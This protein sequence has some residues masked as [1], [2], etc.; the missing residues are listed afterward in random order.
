MS[1]IENL[2]DQQI[3][4]GSWTNW[5]QGRILG[6]TITLNRNNGNLLI[7][8]LALFV[9][10]T[11]T[12]LWR[13]IG[14][15]FHRHFSTAERQ[16]GL[17]HQRQAILRNSDN[18]NAALWDLTY[19]AWIWRRKSRSLRRLSPLLASAVISLIAFA[20]ASLF[21]SR[22][23]GLTGSEVLI[24]S[25]SCGLPWTGSMSTSDRL[26]IMH[27][28]TAQ[29]MNSAM[30]YAQRCYSKNAK[31]ENCDYF[32]RPRLDSTII[33][34]ASCP[35]QEHM[36]LLKNGNIILDTGLVDSHRDL[37][38]NSPISKRTQFRRVDQCAPLIMDNF[39]DT[40]VYQ[41]DDRQITYR[42]Y[43]YGPRLHSK[44]VNY[45]H[46]QPDL[47]IDQLRMQSFKT[48]LGDYRLRSVHVFVIYKTMN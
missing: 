3:Y 33:R 12:C 20:V 34:N 2:A 38:F 37:G 30:S 5:S 6:A 13:I 19:L 24:S 41:G 43:N 25:P 14:F 32:V 22:I 26:S 35:F 39:T 11:G 4:L 16:D 29:M 36:C 42:R 9:S 18:A 47:P 40:Y 23:T 17:Y 8:F 46:I 27:P 28:Y 10:Y 45:T 1:D 7:A 31:M 15:G 44:G 48:T 21:S